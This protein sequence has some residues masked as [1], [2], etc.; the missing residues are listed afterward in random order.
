MGGDV[1]SR[2][3]QRF[4]YVF[5][6]T[7]FLAC[8]FRPDNLSVTLSAPCVFGNALLVSPF[9]RNALLLCVRAGVAQLVE[10]LICNQRVGG[11]SPFA[12]SIRHLKTYCRGGRVVN[13]T[14]L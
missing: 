6:P 12:G 7:I 1:V 8:R 14:G 4:R 3:R 9:C 2:I 13:G 5:K 11:S 10:H